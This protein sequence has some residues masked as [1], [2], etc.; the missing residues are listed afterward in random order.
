MPNCTTQAYERDDV[1]NVGGFSDQVFALVKQFADGTLGNEHWVG[2]I[3]K[4]EL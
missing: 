3:E 4:T 2:E 1:L